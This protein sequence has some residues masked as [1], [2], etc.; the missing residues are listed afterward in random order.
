MKKRDIRMP[1]NIWLNIPPFNKSKWIRDSIRQRFA[2]E[3]YNVTDE[4]M[5][6]LRSS[7]EQ[8]RKVGVHLSQTVRLLH[9]KKIDKPAL[10]YNEL[11]MAVKAVMK[12]VEVIKNKYIIDDE[13]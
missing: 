10:P 8:L 6:S 4:E 12:D 1:D 9:S 11:V 3:I 7:T 13:P 5:N 2:K